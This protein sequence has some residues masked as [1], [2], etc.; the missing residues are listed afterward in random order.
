MY[1]VCPKSIFRKAFTF[2]II[3]LFFLNHSLYAQSVIGDNAGDFVFKYE[4]AGQVKNIPVYY[5]APEKLA[6]DSR[7]VFVLHGAGRSGKSYRNHWQKYAK[8]NNFL[9]LCPE[10]SEKE[11]P[12]WW[13]YN[14]GNIYDKEK[15]RYNPR[16]MWTFNVIESL[17]DFVKK[18]RRMAVGSYCIF[19][20]SAG[21]Q[22]VHRM[23]LF[24]PEARFSMAI[25]NGAGHYTEP[26]FDKKFTDGLKFTPVTEETLKKALRK[27]LIIL[28]GNR[29]RVSRTMPKSRDK[30]HQYDRFWKGELF[31]ETAQAESKK[32]KIELNWRVRTVPNADHNDVRHAQYGAKYAVTS[33]KNLPE[34]N[35]DA[36][37]TDENK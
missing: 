29:D 27:D 37:K 21:A 22:F 36:V 3:S 18:D 5:Y 16:E 31:F 19:G 17:F 12:G 32:R 25:A 13:Q 1:P 26:T 9:V 6:E 23:V 11:F 33:E 24:M 30:L 15:N 34:E 4:I 10:F 35:F 20:H 14:A 28:I 8:L 7:I 2:A